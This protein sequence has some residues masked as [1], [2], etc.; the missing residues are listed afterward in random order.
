M[1]TFVSAAVQNVGTA[2]FNSTDGS[3]CTQR[4][5]RS[6]N[7]NTSLSSCR[8][9]CTLKHLPVENDS[10]QV[11]AL[12]CSAGMLFPFPQERYAPRLGLLY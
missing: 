12:S 4:C 9:G 8:L 5:Y 7:V 2:Y 11:A 10:L 3:Q 1:Q 6:G